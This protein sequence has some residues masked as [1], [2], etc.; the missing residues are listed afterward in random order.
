[1]LNT[2]N[3]INMDYEA[4]LLFDFEPTKQT[5]M[6]DINFTIWAVQIL[7]WGLIVVVVKVILFYFQLWFAVILETMTF[8]LI[9]WLNLYPKVKL[10]T[11]M[12]IVPFILNSLQFWIQDNIL[13]GKKSRN[14]EFT[15]YLRKRRNSMDAGEIKQMIDF[16]PKTRFRTIASR[17]DFKS[18]P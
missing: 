6:A 8:I 14:I 12:M 16:K 17:K 7:V 11:I 10:V 3:Y 2:G 13:I 4:E 15:N 9:G 1:M 18:D 5:E